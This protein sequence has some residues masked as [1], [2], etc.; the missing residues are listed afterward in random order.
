MMRIHVAQEVARG[1]C[2]RWTRE[3]LRHVARENGVA[4]GYPTKYELATALVLA[5]VIV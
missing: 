2:E 5:G 4:T 1:I 3:E